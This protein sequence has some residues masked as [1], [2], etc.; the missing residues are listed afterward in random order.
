MATDGAVTVRASSSATGGWF[1]F[2]THVTVA[3][4]EVSVC[5]SAPA[6]ATIVSA[7]ALPPAYVSVATPAASA[8]TVLVCG[9]A[10]VTV[11]VTAVPAGEATFLTR[12]VKVRA[13]RVNGEGVTVAGES[14]SWG[15]TLVDARSHEP[16]DFVI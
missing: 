14:A 9:L 3:E 16:S 10:P 2:A 11:N 7:P 1:G 6:V 8:S 4:F 12:A 13:T 5:P 15:T